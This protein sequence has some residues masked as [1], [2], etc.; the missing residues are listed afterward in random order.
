MNE[1]IGCLWACTS[2]SFITDWITGPS[3]TCLNALSHIKQRQLNDCEQLVTVQSQAAHNVSCEPLILVLFCLTGYSYGSFTGVSHSCD[4]LCAHELYFTAPL[5][6]LCFYFFIGHFKNGSGWDGR[7]TG[8]VFSR[9]GRHLP[10]C[11]PRPQ[12]H[13]CGSLRQV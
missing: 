8:L 1:T 5:M 3:L 2:T 10:C 13:S 9:G 4:P 6:L 12:H 11:L 7:C